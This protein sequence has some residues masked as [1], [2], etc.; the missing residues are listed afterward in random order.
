MARWQ[1]DREM[2]RKV[3]WALVAAEALALAGSFALIFLAYLRFAVAR[4][5]GAHVSPFVLF[6]LTRY[7]AVGVAA[8]VLAVAVYEGLMF[9]RGCRWARAAFIIENV[10]LVVLGLLWF[11]KNR[12]TGDVLNTEAALYGLLLPMLTLFPLLWPLLVFSPT[13]DAASEM[14]GQG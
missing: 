9:V 7:I 5:G 13:P 12:I 11:V 2:R 3:A 14:R 10:A 1:R 6:D 8:V 4:L